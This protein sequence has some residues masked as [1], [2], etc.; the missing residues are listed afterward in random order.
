MMWIN[1]IK[2][3][4]QSI[5]FRGHFI[6]I[7][8]AKTVKVLLV[9]FMLVSLLFIP[10]LITDELTT[11]KC[12]AKALTYTSSRARPDEIDLTN[13]L[14]PYIWR[15]D[16]DVPPH[17]DLSDKDY[18][19]RV[20]PGVT[21]IIHAGVTVDFASGRQLLIEGTLYIIGTPT[22]P[23]NLTLNTTRS[24]GSQWSGV[25]LTAG[26]SGYINHSNISFSANGVN[27]FETNNI[28]I[29][30]CSIHDVNFGVKL[31]PD[32]NNNLID[33]N[34]IF[35]CDT[36]IGIYNSDN[37]I[38]FN[39]YVNNSLVSGI[40]ISDYA[41]NNEIK[42]NYFFNSSARGISLSGNANNNSFVSNEIYLHALDGIRCTNAMD[43]VFEYN[44]IYSNKKNGMILFYGSERCIINYNTITQN[45]LNGL[46]LVGLRSG[47]VRLNEI[48]GNGIGVAGD[49]SSG[50][51]LENNTIVS[52]SNAD[53]FLTDFSYITSVNSTFNS[54]KVIVY[55]LSKFY[56]YWHMF[57]ETRDETN[58]I[59]P[60]NVNITNSSSGIIVPETDIAGTLDWI[61][62]LG[63]IYTSYGQDSSM[64]PYW[65]RA[66]NG[67]KV[68]KLGFDLSKGSK[69]CVVKFV[70]YPP[71]ESTLPT[72]FD[73]KEDNS[74]EINISHYFTSSE[75]LEY[76]IKRLTGNDIHYAYYPDTTILRAMPPSNWYGEE[77][78]RIIA[79]ANLGGELPRETKIIVTSVNDKP[80]INK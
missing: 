65:I 64:N 32:C 49:N 55:D 52:S 19:F 41:N 56:V 45:T 26:S 28:R 39:N 25:K 6:V 48:I 58:V 31:D 40:S 74:I 33:S 69:T 24:P 43:N 76:D 78:M 20:W 4:C 36:G 73:L 61:L 47:E 1:I 75:E 22:R 35:N 2:S 51:E 70:Y 37:N 66:D 16:S 79:M 62:C 14:V 11:T 5:G 77:R 53:I 71:P 67:S 27:L 23:V 38:I 10:G 30:N 80:F 59:T 15:T 29:T 17:N 7:S 72:S 9:C 34:Q 60:A 50:I 13:T 54:S 57:I 46:S 68:L 18:G 63:S 12:S 21:L 8:R 3:T 42:S 44:Q